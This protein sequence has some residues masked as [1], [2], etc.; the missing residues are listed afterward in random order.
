MGK[1]AK[2]KNATAICDRTGRKHP[3]SEM[4]VE[5]GTKWLVHWTESDGKWNL[6]TNPRNYPSKPKKE[7]MGLKEARP[8]RIEPDVEGLDE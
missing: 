3:Y 1:F 5:P 6:V 7:G 2:G 8:D 4:V